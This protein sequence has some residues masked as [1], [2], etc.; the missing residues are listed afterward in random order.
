MVMAGVKFKV[1][2]ESDGSV[3]S[4]IQQINIPSPWPK[5]KSLHPYLHKSIN[6]FKGHTIQNEKEI[7]LSTNMLA[8][9][10]DNS[11]PTSVLSAVGFEAFGS[12]S[13]SL[14]DFHM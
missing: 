8:A 1:V 14:V 6:S 5:R 11:S 3:E 7:S 4:S 13:L 2:R 10:K 9:E 12:A